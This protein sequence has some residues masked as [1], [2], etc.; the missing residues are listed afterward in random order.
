MPLVTTAWLPSASNHSLWVEM[1]TPIS[2]FLTDSKPLYGD[3][4]APHTV[5]SIS[6]LD[7]Q[8]FLSINDYAQSIANK[9]I[10]SRY[11]PL[12]VARWI[13]EMVASSTSALAKA[14]K[15]TAGKMSS[16]AFRRAE[17]DIVILNC[18]GGYFAALFRAALYYSLFEKT[19]DRRIA[20]K[21][22][23]CYRFALNSWKKLSTIS[24]SVYQDDV[25][26]GSVAERR[27]HWSDRLSGIEKDVA[28]L[29]RHLQNTE[30]S[31]IETDAIDRLNRPV[32]RWS[33]S[34]GHTAPLRFRAG[35]DLP[36]SV[37]TEEQIDEIILWYRHVTHAERWRS[38][39]M[40]KNEY[41]FAASI[42]GEYTQSLFP[43][44]YYFEVRKT[45]DATL[46]PALNATLSNQPYF[47]VF[48]RA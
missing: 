47:S 8:L 4:P 11:N 17:E 40:K 26:Y 33:P 18:L 24:K 30:A 3:S 44:Q 9:E 13:D 42:P 16:S 7:P 35:N 14:H 39:K 38:S 6:P 22:L 34:I 25:S 19:G 27:G 21:A 32:I 41:T 29:E 20:T 28:A 43:L 46:Y 2:I 23:E 12:E 36:I 48:R 15:T 37:T 45:Q 1:Y 31:T 5:G 10:S